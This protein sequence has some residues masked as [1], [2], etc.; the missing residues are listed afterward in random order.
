M[1]TQGF[2]DWQLWQAKT[3]PRQFLQDDATGAIYRGDHFKACLFH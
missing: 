2:V 1:D 3:H